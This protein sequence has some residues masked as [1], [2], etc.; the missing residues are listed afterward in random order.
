MK[1]EIKAELSDWLPQFVTSERNDLINK[2]LKMRTRR[3]TAVLENIFQPHNASAVLRS[4]DI[5]GIQDV[6]IIEDVYEYTVNPDV[7]MGASRWLTLHRY[8]QPDPLPARGTKGTREAADIRKA[9]L[10]STPDCIEQLK[11]DGYAIVATS[12]RPGAVSLYDLPIDKPLALCFGT[13]E[14]GLSDVAHELADVYMTIPMVGF[15]QSFNISVSAALSLQ[16]LTHK[17][18]QSSTDW[19][20]SPAEAKDIRLAWLIQSATKGDALV[21]QFLRDRDE[22]IP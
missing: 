11:Q 6:H 7:A 21:R 18:R 17:L 14:T 5:F 19:P 10:S 4:C 8:G 12:L 13:E 1:P 20:L 3:I 9:T 16:H 22:A 15:T 2:I